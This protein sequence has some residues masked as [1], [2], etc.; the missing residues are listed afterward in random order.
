[1]ASSA[2]TTRRQVLFFPREHGAYAELLF[3]LMGAFIIGAAN[4]AA[5]AISLATIAAFVIHE[6]VWVVLGR[7]GSRSRREH[8][9]DA[10]R[11]LLVVTLVAVA[12]GV[13]GFVLAPVTARWALVLGLGLAALPAVLTAA[14]R[15][16]S[17]A[18]EILLA[19]SLSSPSVAVALATGVSLHTALCA[20]VVWGVGYSVSTADIRTV[21]GRVR[22]GYASHANLAIT[23]T[24]LAGMLAAVL[25]RLLPATYLL[26]V[27]PLLAVGIVLRLWRV[28]PR[29]LRAAGWTLVGASGVTLVLLAFVAG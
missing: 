22:R 1:M 29:R 20:W 27:A 11:F 19:W 17:L 5:A 23:V 24:G 3:P 18:G 26:A 25:G 9:R 13:A 28:H 15:E 21:I 8:G 2:A 10:R 7:R 12:S 4:A 6:P 16:R 14:D